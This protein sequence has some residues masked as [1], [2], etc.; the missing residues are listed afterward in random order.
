R[1]A[2]AQCPF[3]DGLASAG[4]LGPRES[5]TM[6]GFVVRDLLAAARGKAPVA[7]PVAALPG[8]PGLM[9]APDA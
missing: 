8:A 2:V 6:F 4:A 7:I 5:L 3:T 1:A 9:T